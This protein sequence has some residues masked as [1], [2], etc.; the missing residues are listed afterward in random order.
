MM[1]EGKRRAVKSATKEQLSS[2]FKGLCILHYTLE[3]HSVGN[4]EL[5]QTFN[6][7]CI[8]GVEIIIW[9]EGGG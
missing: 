1:G 4:R 3:L 9:I 2:V 7:D 6:L 8:F 5:L